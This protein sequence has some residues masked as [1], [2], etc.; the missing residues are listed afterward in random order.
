MSYRWRRNSSTLTN[1][2]VFSHRAFF[3]VVAL[4]AAEAGTYTVVVTN[5]VF[6]RP[7][8]LSAPATLT[9]LPDA[10]GDGMADA[11][12]TAHQLNPNDPA[13]GLLDADMDGMS[14]REEYR[15]GSDP[16]NAASYLAVE[17]LDAGGSARIEFNA[18]SNMTYT[19]EYRDRLEFGFWQKLSD[20][21]ARG[22]NRVE[23]VFDPHSRAQRFY[24]IVTPRQADLD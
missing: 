12:E 3:T 19:V 9:V 4:T 18:V 20:V 21:V 16:N 24:R 8:L 17:S 15:S 13:D 7:G 22:T 11:W 1:Y 23:S 14:N 10:D 6:Y 5:D 2:T